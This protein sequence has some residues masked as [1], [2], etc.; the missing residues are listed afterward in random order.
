MLSP[1]QSSANVGFHQVNNLRETSS[2]QLEGSRCLLNDRGAMPSF[3]PH[4]LTYPKRVAYFDILKRASEPTKI[5]KPGD[6][7]V[8][9]LPPIND[10]AQFDAVGRYEGLKSL[11]MEPLPKRQRIFEP[12]HRTSG[13]SFVDKHEY[14]DGTANNEIMDQEEDFEEEEESEEDP[15]TQLQHRRARLDYKL[16]S[17]FEAIFEKY[18]KDFDGLG[19][20][21]DLET[22]EIV[23]NNGHLTKMQDERDAGDTSKARRALRE[24]TAEAEDSPTSYLDTDMLEDEKEY[25]DI[26][27]ENEDDTESTT[28]DDGIDD[29]MILRGFAK[30]NRF[31]QKPAELKAPNKSP[32]RKS[33]RKEHRQAGTRTK[34]MPSRSDILMQFGPELGPHIAKFVSQQQV[35]DSPVQDDSHIESAWRVPRIPFPKIHQPTKK[36]F[37]MVPEPERSPS[38]EAANSIWNQ[39]RRIKHAQAPPRY[40]ESL[41][42]DPLSDP[43]GFCYDGTPMSTPKKIYQSFS[44]GDDQILLDFVEQARRQNLELGSLDTWVLLEEMVCFPLSIKCLIT[45]HL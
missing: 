14:Y 37:K 5:A 16:K 9:K 21:I 41:M 11:N 19:D 13:Q 30:A 17:T 22:G 27:E 33:R 18:G 40:Y 39:G 2:I 34:I 3:L 10:N 4:V 28:S 20:E 6:A 24:F 29:G 44:P 8:T 38:P 15:D 31:I 32:P 12:A 1:V 35:P 25:E 26:D 43:M 23:V 42:L 45:K 7:P 36:P